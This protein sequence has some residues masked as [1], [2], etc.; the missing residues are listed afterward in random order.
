MELPDGRVTVWRYRKT[1]GSGD[2]GCDR[3][4]VWRY[5]ETTNSGATGQTDGGIAEARLHSGTRLP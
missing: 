2:A 4:T 1:A 3:V 5:R